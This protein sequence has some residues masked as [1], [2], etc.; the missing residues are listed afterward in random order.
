VLLE[1]IQTIDLDEDAVIILADHGYAVGNVTAPADN[2]SDETARNR[3]SAFV[4]VSTPKDCEA[5]IP[6]DLST[7]QILPHV[8]NCHGAEVPIPPHRFMKVNHQRFGGLGA[9][10]LVWDGWSAY[11]P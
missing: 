2:W 8:L 9:T 7:A 1:A 5:A 6:E 4:A 11:S 10:E 3:L